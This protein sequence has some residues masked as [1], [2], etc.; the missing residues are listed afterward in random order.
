MSVSKES[1]ELAR[2]QQ[3]ILK[4]FDLD[5]FDES[6]VVECIDTIYDTLESDNYINDQVKKKLRTKAQ[7]V[8]SDDPKFG[9]LLLYS[10]ENFDIYHNMIES[11]IKKEI[12]QE[13]F[14]GNF[15]QCK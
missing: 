2:Y 5:K 10:L 3:S 15:L 14:T 11:A 7:Y 4:L 13:E 8:H 6:K 12:T 1:D 9:F